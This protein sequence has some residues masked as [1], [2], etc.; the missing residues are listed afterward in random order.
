MK[1]IDTSISL[2][3][4][5]SILALINLDSLDSQLGRIGVVLYTMGVIINVIVLIIEIRS[6]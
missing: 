1:N 5:F 4:I 6:R 2:I 3:I